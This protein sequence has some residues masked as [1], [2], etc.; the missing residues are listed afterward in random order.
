MTEEKTEKAHEHLKKG[1]SFLQ[2]GKRE[3]ALEEFKGALER[4]PQNTYIHY[5]IAYML[6]DLSYLKETSQIFKEIIG[7]SDKS[8]AESLFLGSV[9]Y[10]L[11]GDTNRAICRLRQFLGTKPRGKIY[12]EARELLNYLS[13]EEKD[14]YLTPTYLKTYNKYAGEIEAMRKEVK[15]RLEC[16]FIRITMLE[17]LYKQLE[18][19]KISSII[20]LYGLAD[21]SHVAERVLRQYI[22][23]SWIKEKHREL[24]LLALRDMGAEEPFETIIY[25]RL[26]KVTLKE[27]FEKLRQGDWQP[28]WHEVLNLAREKILYSEHYDNYRG[29]MLEVDLEFFWSKYLNKVYPLVPP[30]D[31]KKEWAGALELYVL[32]KRDLKA[33]HKRVALRYGVDPHRLWE[34]YRTIS[35][36]LRKEKKGPRG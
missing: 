13:G 14:S 36:A 5:N 3:K 22:K 24:G 7:E 20:F 1:T 30:L 9:F 11:R 12:T 25:N 6:A 2:K 19:D 31:N 32:Q 18:D 16:P 17:S 4:D 35:T 8:L 26:E 23:N 10:T 15:A 28:G 21:K 33:N 29:R 27:F 34:I